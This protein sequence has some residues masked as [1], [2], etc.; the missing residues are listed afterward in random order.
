MLGIN[1]VLFKNHLNGKGGY[2]PRTVLNSVYGSRELIQR[3]T[4][5]GGFRKGE[6]ESFFRELADVTGELMI[7]GHGIN[8]NNLIKIY[9]VVKGPFD[10]AS[11]GFTRGRNY[12]SIN[13]SVSKAFV[14]KLMS[15]I[16]VNKVESREVVPS[17]KEIIDNP[18]K[19]NALFQDIINVIDGNNLVVENWTFKSLTIINRENPEMVERVPVE[20]LNISGLSKKKIT[21]LFRR[22]FDPPEWLTKGRE[23]D[24]NFVYYDEEKKQTI[25]GSYFTT[26][27]L[28]D[29]SEAPAP[30][31]PE[32]PIA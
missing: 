8:I 23:I 9:P 15:K 29:D 27:W 25:N 13:A 21:F 11:D 30:K 32:K 17:I 12:I 10:S 24:I 26:T 18:L 22:S 7:E 19:L 28:L 20:Q 31:E 4:D 14:D 3:M 6:Y 5:K 1:Y 2:L 16:T